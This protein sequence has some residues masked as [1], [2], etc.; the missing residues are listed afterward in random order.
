MKKIF[1]ICC[2]LF[3]LLFAFSEPEARAQ[4]M[5]VPDAVTEIEEEAF[6]QNAGITVLVLHENVSL[7]SRAFSDCINLS[8]LVFEGEGCA[9]APDAFEGCPLDAVYC[10]E[11]T[12]AYAFADE[13]GL[14]IYPL[15]AFYSDWD[16]D[17]VTLSDGSARITAYKGV[18][19]EVSV[20]E[21]VRGIR[22]TEIGENAFRGKKEISR[23]ALPDG[24]R[25]IGSGAFSDCQFLSR[26]NIPESVREIGD[27]PFVNCSSLKNPDISAGNTYFSMENGVMLSRKLKR[28]I[29]FSC[30]SEATSVTIPEGIEIIGKNAF[31]RNASLKKVVFPGSLREIE[32]YAF[33]ECV[34]LKTAALP[35]GLEKIGAYAF[36]DCR[37]LSGISF[38]S[39]LWE[40]GDYAFKNCAALKN[41]SL[42]EGTNA[43]KN[44]FY[45]ESSVSGTVMNIQP[46]YQFDY[47]KTICVF[48][49]EEKSVA[50]SGCGATCLSMA[51]RYLKG[52]SEQTPETL[53]QWAYDSG[54]YTGDGLSHAA[55]SRIASRYGL[56]ATWT[57]STTS[58]LNAL[59]KGQPVVA[60]MGAGTFAESGHYI[61]LRGVNPDGLIV[62]NDPNSRERTQT[63]Y[64][65]SQIAAELKTSSGFCI[66][67]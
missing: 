60:H 50:T 64:P 40:V 25:K 46:L 11:G 49:G 15:S 48:Y 27:N 5:V 17:F 16:F 41:A 10:E 19:P 62:L 29:Y 58:V 45:N 34:Q 42:P 26:I 55:L 20:L 54:Y 56:T 43:G 63:A 31:R 21:Y 32:A 23:V 6:S 66:L 52:N 37:I 7:D 35:A 2:F 44:V 28:A 1:L 51:I 65:L 39:A 57:K 53:F 33:F 4:T 3:L 12:D 61:L 59:K 8:V 9:F 36:S 13:N 22:V 14:L 30:S 38:P 67:Q 18:S 24:L 47:R